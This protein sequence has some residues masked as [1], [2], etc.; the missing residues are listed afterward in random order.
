MSDAH[1]VDPEHYQRRRYD[2]LVRF[3]S[4][5]HQAD[6]VLKRAPEQVLEIGIGNGF[7]SRYLRAKG[8]EVHTVDVDERLGPDT[9]AS[10]VDLPF[11]DQ[12]FDLVACFETLEHIPWDQFAPAVTELRRVA[13]RWVLLSL[14][15]ASP[16][17]RIDI[18]GPGKRRI[19]RL[20]ELPYPRPEPHQFDGE[21]YW[22]MGKA[23]FSRKRIIAELAAVGL[24]VEERLRVFELPYHHFLSCTRR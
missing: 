9:V 3:I 4:Y 18:E 2:K 12:H 10:V 24:E 8:M 23:G 19:Q 7:L 1:Q 22:E 17:L 14:P 5:W 16:Y 20:K 6:Q 15:D 21:H 13:K 11:D